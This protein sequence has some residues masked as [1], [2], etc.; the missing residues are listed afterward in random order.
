M[1]LCGHRAVEGNEE[2]GAAAIMSTR[3]VAQVYKGTSAQSYECAYA[4]PEVWVSEVRVH[5]GHADTRAMVFICMYTQTHIHT[6][7]IQAREPQD[8]RH[9]GQDSRD[10]LRRRRRG[11]HPAAFLQRQLKSCVVY[12]SIGRGFSFWL[13]RSNFLVGLAIAFFL[14]FF[15]VGITACD[16]WECLNSV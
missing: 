3:K 15:S 11:G 12:Y 7:F 5:C 2:V 13:V 9:G 8:L 6:M 4:T 1:E 16:A 14:S 10:L